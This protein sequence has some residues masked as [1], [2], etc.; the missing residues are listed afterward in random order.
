M[1]IFFGTG[2]KEKNS[3]KDYRLLESELAYKEKLLSITNAIHAAKDLE[4]IFL[5]LQ[6][7]I[8]ELFDAERITIYA[9]DPGANELF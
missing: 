5:K 7:Q 9:V 4:E 6:G 8:L 2:T 3:E 1:P